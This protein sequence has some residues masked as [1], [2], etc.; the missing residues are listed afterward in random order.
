VVDL[1]PPEDNGKGK[2]VDRTRV[3]SGHTSL[4]PLHGSPSLHESPS[5]HGSPLHGSST[6]PHGSPFRGH[7]SISPIESIHGGTV[8]DS[9]SDAG[10]DVRTSEPAPV[11]GE[12]EIAMLITG[13]KSTNDASEDESRTGSGHRTKRQRLNG[14]V[15][16]QTCG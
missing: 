10:V 15:T 16:A 3:W 8:E 13:D 6:P 14:Q 9:D 2:S 12:R 4:S 11:D 1:N 5:L 7:R